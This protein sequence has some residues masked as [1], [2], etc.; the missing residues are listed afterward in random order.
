MLKKYVIKIVQLIKYAKGIHF[1]MNICILYG[2]IL[3]EIKFDFLYNSKKHVSV[4]EF[5]ILVNNQVFSKNKKEIINIKAYDECAD[6]VYQNFNKEDFIGI[7]GYF[8]G[9]DVYIKDILA[10]NTI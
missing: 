9:K 10:N 8:N 4:V 2:K 3:S 7:Y 5:K 1:I 6:V